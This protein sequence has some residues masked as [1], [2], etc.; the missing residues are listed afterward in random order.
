MLLG[1]IVLVVGLLAFQHATAQRHARAA[2]LGDS[3]LS[4]GRTQEALRAYERSFKAR[5]TSRAAFGIGE[6]NRALGSPTDTTWFRKALVLAGKEYS[7]A[8]RVSLKVSSIYQ[9]A[10]CHQ[11]LGEHEAAM[12]WFSNLACKDKSA[13]LEIARSLMVLGRY[14]EA[15]VTLDHIADR[16]PVESKA[17]MDECQRALRK[18]PV[19]QDEP[20]ERE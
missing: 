12:K 6:C 20:I 14:E 13:Y 17:L 5:K 7:R 18:S 11:R 16:Y 1:R 19:E 10:Y 3:L 4:L 8:E 15:L 2:N 9:M